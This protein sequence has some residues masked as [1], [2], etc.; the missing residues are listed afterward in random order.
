MKKLQLLALALFATTLAFAQPEKGDIFL[1][2]SLNFNMGSSKGEVAGVSA[3]G[4]KTLNFG[5]SPRV[6]YFLSDK[7]VV[8]LDLG[9]N[10]ASSN[11][12]SSGT[13]IKTSSSMYGGGVFARYYIVPADRFALFFEAGVGAMLGGSK[14][15]TA[16]VSVD[17]PNSFNL[18]AGLTPGVAF[19]VSKRVALEANYGFL[20]YTSTSTKI[21]TAGVETKTN[22]GNFGLNINPSTFEFGMSILF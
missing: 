17:G 16:G 2:G 10:S 1:G 18:N 15:E 3:D 6:G 20:G 8:G 19:Y 5:I 21:E 22:A 14:V 11:D 13:E 9:F 12:D 7:I 4:P